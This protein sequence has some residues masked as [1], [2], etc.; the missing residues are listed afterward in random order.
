M[1][2]KTQNQLFLLGF[3]PMEEALGFLTTKTQPRME[4]R[5]AAALWR[6]ANDR[7]QQSLPT[8]AGAC[9]RVA[10]EELPADLKAP[11]AALE[12]TPLFQKS[13][14]AVPARVMMVE[15]APL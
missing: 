2:G 3:P 9:N 14:A 12:S 7:I 5:T 8:D 1:D 4:V 13:F 6:A 10:V 15:L 11:A